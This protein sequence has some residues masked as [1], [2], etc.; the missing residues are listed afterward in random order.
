MGKVTTS[1]SMS[2][3]GFIA[4]PNP[5]VEHPLGEG[6]ERLHRWMFSIDPGNSG[7]NAEIVAIATGD[8]GAVVMGNRMYVCGD[9]PWG[10]AAPYQ[11][12]T[13][14][15]THHPRETVMRKGVPMR[16]VTD[17]FQSAFD[18]AK[19]AAGDG[20]ILVAGGA[21]IVQ[22]AFNAGLLD[23][24]QIQLIPVLFGAGRRLFENLTTAPIELE[25]EL[26]IEGTGV[27]HLQFRVV[28]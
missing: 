9:A 22:Q 24:I 14:I 4:G 11:A 27:T 19:A 3:D 21:N 13:F 28:K 18:Q 10:D 8:L 23:E 16:F 2:L 15:V 20:A 6:G 17:G 1:F 12:P 5:G 26:L 25:R 7:R